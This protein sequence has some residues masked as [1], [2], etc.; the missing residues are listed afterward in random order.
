[1]RAMALAPSPS[2]TRAIS[3]MSVTLG[4]SLIRSGSDVARLV[5]RV[6]RASSSGRCPNSM[7][8]LFT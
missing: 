4:E 5:S 3:A 7:P 1:M 6:S 2:H 8:P